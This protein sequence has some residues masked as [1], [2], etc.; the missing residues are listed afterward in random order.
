MN[1]RVAVVWQYLIPQRLVCRVVYL[2]ARCRWRWFAGPLKRWFARH[3]RLDLAEADR[4][5]PDDY[6]T[7]NALF[8]RA[9]KVGARPLAAARDAAVS[10]ADGTL[11]AFGPI[12]NGTLLEAKG[13]AYS[14]TELLGEQNVGAFADGS[15]ATVYLAPP[16]YHRVHVPFGGRLTATRYIAGRR[17]SVNA[18]TTAA[19]PNLFCRNERAVLSIDVGRWAYRLVMIGAL[20]V[21][22]ISTLS[23]GEIPS[24]RSAS[25]S[26]PEP[27]AIRT[28]AEIGRFNLGSTVIAVFPSGVLHWLGDLVAGQ[29]VRM[30]QQLGTI[31]AGAD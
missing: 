18:A 26:E 15:F 16:D 22:S 19:V 27:I 29:T 13:V 14:L 4:A 9:L 10:P 8:T 31:V 7:L 3:Y 20:N 30:G 17:F 25:W 12:G 23:R 2:A 11:T 24:G 6:E 5:S 1:F 21:S 28:G